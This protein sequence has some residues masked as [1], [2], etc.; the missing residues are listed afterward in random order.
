MAHDSLFSTG[1]FL[2]W[3]SSHTMAA[4]DGGG[5]V[6][7]ASSSFCPPLPSF[8][9][10]VGAELVP[11]A[12][13]LSAA[14]MEEWALGS[15]TF[16]PYASILQSNELDEVALGLVSS[17]DLASLGLP[18]G[19][20]A[21]LRL[22]VAKYVAD[23]GS[24]NRAAD[25]PRPE[26]TVVATVVTTQQ[27]HHRSLQ[28]TC[29]VNT[30]AAEVQV[31]CCNEPTEDCSSGAP[32]S[33][34]AGCA[35]IFLPFWADCQQQLG[36]S[37]SQYLNIVQMCRDSVGCGID[38]MANMT[39]ECCTGGHRRT[40][41][42]SG[43][44][45]LMSD[46]TIECEA[47]Y[48]PLYQRC[49]SAMGWNANPEYSS[50]ALQCAAPRP[51][52]EPEPKPEPTPEPPPPPSP[53]WV[54]NESSTWVSNVDHV[55]CSQYAPGATT[56]QSMCAVHIGFEYNQAAAQYAMQSSGGNLGGVQFMTA[57]QAC[58]ISCGTCP[59]CMD[60]KQ[61][62][63]ETG[64]D[65]GGSCQYCVRASS[66]G[67]IESSGLLGSNVHAICT[68]TT[69]GSTCLARPA[70]GHRVSTPGTV[71]ELCAASNISS[72]AQLAQEC[73]AQAATMFVPPRT[74]LPGHVT[75][76]FTGRWEGDQLHV[77][78]IV[79]T[80]CPTQLVGQH[81]SAT[82]DPTARQCVPQ[83][84]AGYPSV[85]GDGVFTCHNG[86][87]VG[88]L[89]CE[90]I[91]CG[92]TLDNMPLADSA[93]AE[94][95]DGHYLGDTCTA[96]CREGFYSTVGTGSASFKC[97]QTAGGLWMQQGFSP[98]WESSLQCTR[99]P[100][101]ENCVVSSCTTGGDAQ[102]LQC[103]DGF[104]AY[105]HNEDPTRCL[106]DSVTTLAAG[107]T[108]TAVGSF[109]FVFTGRHLPSD[110]ADS[111]AG[112]SV[113][114]TD[115]ASMQVTGT[116]GQVVGA[117]FTIRGQ[118]TLS[119]LIL[120]GGSITATGGSS[121]SVLLSSG[122]LLNIAV[123]D[124]SFVMDNS[125]TVLIEGNINFHNAGIVTLVNKTFS[126][127]TI[128]SQRCR[129]SSGAGTQLKLVACTLSMDCALDCAD[130]SLLLDDVHMY[131]VRANGTARTL[132]ASATTWELS[133]GQ[134]DFVGGAVAFSTITIGA[135]YSNSGADS[136]NTKLTIRSST[137]PTS[138]R[139]EVNDGA[140]LIFAATTLQVSQLTNSFGSFGSPPTLDGAGSVIE[141]DKVHIPGV[142]WACN[143]SLTGT[144][145][146]S[147][148]SANP[149]TMNP[150][151]LLGRRF[152]VL[153]GPCAVSQ[154]GRCV[155]RPHGYGFGP[156]PP[157][158]MRGSDHDGDS[159][160]DMPV[161]STSAERCTIKVRSGGILGPCPVFY[162]VDYGEIGRNTLFSGNCRSCTGCTW[163]GRAC[164]SST[165]FFSARHDGIT[166]ASSGILYSGGSG[167]GLQGT[168]A[169]S[170]SCTS[171]ADSPPATRR[172]LCTGCPVG[173]NLP[174]NDT[175]TWSSSVDESFVGIS[176]RHSENCDH[177][178]N[179]AATANMAGWQICFA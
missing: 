4:A 48:L 32:I 158:A 107:L 99:C 167:R 39:A 137:V 49:G 73:A 92:V 7:A 130:A 36:S 62:G 95:T 68:G 2:L 84:D 66:C 144:V 178:K 74:A 155:G 139:L 165:N 125:S 35:A 87:W 163:Q 140:R 97:M 5:A 24:I 127:G 51:E 21:K 157:P 124:S 88:D 132:S 75:C 162:T 160:H 42:G 161:R 111:V 22:C 104:Y 170:G 28:A 115:T 103:N 151:E 44:T 59:T 82:C 110:L 177:N 150:P 176:G 153:S 31:E 108:A 9:H 18:L 94:C 135:T 3:L 113:T 173:V 117:S 60:G 154:A 65:C 106:A 55:G 138:T 34:N 12:A 142:G 13:T 136:A 179:F 168:Y 118:L 143:S 54:C 81:Y 72:S 14:Q 15:P 169:V 56:W 52:P 26:P 141:F 33:C 175:L 69:T 50:F 131:G 164:C 86:V 46:C 57:A 67:P 11:T 20:A 174:T 30:R 23:R 114:I 93:F 38:A 43:C 148:S 109:D 85:R 78:P 152:E 90:P 58:P 53:P 156:G 76:T 116:M 45:A 102:C 64:V 112:S 149:H 1:V 10:M 146:V 134:I 77:L 41:G 147:G 19:V 37:A 172:G 16:A 27:K 70:V 120:S 25:L 29:S 126:A 171:V 123:T 119:Q 101:I 91:S 63:D 71:A 166:V 80:T 105:R 100:T 133:N 83:C 61:N 17:Q 96:R 79:A 89:V 129:V 122:R 128:P 159:T 47:V 40:Q 121:V 8:S 6:A 145:T 98:W